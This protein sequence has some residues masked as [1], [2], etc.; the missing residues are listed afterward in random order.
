MRW[1]SLSRPPA[2][3][4]RPRVTSG[5]PNCASSLATTRSQASTSSNPPAS[6]Y[7][8][9]AAITGLT[10]GRRVIAGQEPLQIHACAESAA[11]AGQD[12]DAD[13]LAPVQILDGLGDAG[14]DRPVDRVPHFGPVDG[15]DGDTV[16]NLDENLVRHVNPPEFSSG[17]SRAGARRP[18]RRRHYF[19]WNLI[20]PSNRTTSAFM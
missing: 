12:E 1:C 17:Q 3:A 13:V 8:S 14:R 9:T 6:A 5:R 2:P 7:P 19:G 16:V 18:G 15:D 11:G 10:G 4:A 20:P